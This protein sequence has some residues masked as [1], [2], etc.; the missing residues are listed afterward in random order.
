MLSSWLFIPGSKEKHVQKAK[1][2]D[3]HVVILDL[4]DSVTIHE[5]KQ[6]RS[7]VYRTLQHLTEKECYVRVNGL[8]TEECMEDFYELV[9]PNL[10]GIILPKVNSRDD[11]LI[12]DFFIQKIENQKKIK[13][14]TIRLVPLIETAE[15]VMNALE[16][17]RASSRVKSLAFGAEDYMLDMNISTDKEEM[18]LLHARSMLVTASRAA[19]IDPPIDSVFTDFYDDEGLLHSTNKGKKLGFGAKL[20][21]HPRQIGAVNRIYS[22]TEEEI[23]RAK[24]IVSAYEEGSLKGDGAIQLEGEMIDKPV[25]ERAKKLL[26]YE[27]K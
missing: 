14:E 1:D 19:R 16:I 25:V 2:V 22:P 10:N 13:P 18:E 23:E 3:A 11:I 27:K 24:L 6:A 15:G 9:G 20:L 26:L 8:H 5:K 17:A 12:A 21:I 4:E 7:I